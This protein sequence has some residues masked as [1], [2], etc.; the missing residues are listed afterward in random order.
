[1]QLLYLTALLNMF[2]Q[3]HSQQ[4]AYEPDTPIIIFT[5]P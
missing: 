1:M 4:T 3:G 5:M 2:Y